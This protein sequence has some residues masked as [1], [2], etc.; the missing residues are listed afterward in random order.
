MKHTFS[1]V[2]NFLAARRVLRRNRQV[3]HLPYWLDGDRQHEDGSS[4]GQGQNAVDNRREVFVTDR[5]FIVFHDG[6][7]VG[8]FGPRD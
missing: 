3:T 6:V 4:D 7:R 1:K 5:R 8:L 2:A